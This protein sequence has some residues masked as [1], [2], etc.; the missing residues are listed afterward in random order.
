MFDRFDICEAWYVYATLNHGGQGSKG[1]A[2]FGRLDRMGYSP[3]WAAQSGDTACLSDN[4]RAIYAGL[5][6]GESRVRNTEE[7]R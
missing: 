7:R 2:I 5:V 1:Y 3:G 4:T 6:S